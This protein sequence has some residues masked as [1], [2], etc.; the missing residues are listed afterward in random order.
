MGSLYTIT[1]LTKVVGKRKPVSNR[2]SVIGMSKEDARAR[3]GAMYP[4]QITDSDV[5][6]IEKHEDGICAAA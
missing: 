4:A 2:W 5:V 3:F 6:V 1:V